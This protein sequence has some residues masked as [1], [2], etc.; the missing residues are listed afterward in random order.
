MKKQLTHQEILEFFD[1]VW[2]EEDICTRAEMIADF[3]KVYKKSDF[4]KH[5]R[6]SLKEL[7]V[8]YRLN[9]LFTIKN[10]IEH[11]NN[12]IRGLDAQTF[13][14]MMDQVNVKTDEFIQEKKDELLDN[15]FVQMLLNLNKTNKS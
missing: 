14:D 2:Q 11:I 15:E 12:V 9:N 10:M 3:Q 5:T 7:Y 13:I 1:K 8:V 4:Y 6:T